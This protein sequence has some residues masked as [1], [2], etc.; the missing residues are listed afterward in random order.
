MYDL[1]DGV[2]DYYH[3]GNTG[4]GFNTLCEFYPTE[5][6]GFMIMVNDN[7]SQEKVSQLETDL[8]KAFKK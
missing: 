1:E 7:I 6:L 5:Q 2:A 3:S 8:H 4:L